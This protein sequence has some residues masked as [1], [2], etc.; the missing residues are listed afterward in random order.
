MEYASAL[1]CGQP[2]GEEFMPKGPN[3]ERRPADAIARAVLVGK[4]A[5]GEETDDK[6][7]GKV[8]SGKA[9]AKARNDNLS[10]ERRAEIA[11][12]AAETRWKDGA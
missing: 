10:P 2:E 3:G 11:K 7:S 8:R 12:I 4:I 5:V 9:G 1:A 6:K